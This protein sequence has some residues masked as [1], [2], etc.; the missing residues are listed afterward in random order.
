MRLYGIQKLTLLDF[1][2]H[3]ACTL[4]TGGCNLRC[5]FCHNASLVLRPEDQMDNDDVL[6]FLRERRGRLQGICLTGGEPLIQSGV[7][8]FL[9]EVRE[10]GYQIK[11]DSNG[12]FPEKLRSLV[13]KGL[14]DYVAMDVKNCPE[15]YPETVGVPELDLGPVRE[16]ISFLLEGTV[17]YEFRTTVVRELHD[18]E[19][20]LSLA[21]WIQGTKRYFL[22]AFT[23]SGDLITDKCSG[24]KPEELR[25]LLKAVQTVIPQAELRG[26]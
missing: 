10:I 8:E 21:R 9:S 23:D 19:S 2:G 7:A 26:V 22:Q 11:L 20:L 1:P 17:D 13:E 4:F 25:E 24:Y 18:E 14:V 3:L 6:D 12:C 16:S 15:R 5:P